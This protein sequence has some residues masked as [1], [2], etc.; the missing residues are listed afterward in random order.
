[1]LT[2]VQELWDRNSASWREVCLKRIVLMLTKKCVGSIQ[3]S[4]S[5]QLLIS[6]N[7]S[8]KYVMRSVVK[9]NLLGYQD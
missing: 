4:M 8:S 3:T 1:M 5:F 7:A 9:E 2:Q 6:S